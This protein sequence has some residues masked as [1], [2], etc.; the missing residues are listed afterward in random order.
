MNKFLPGIFEL[1]FKIG[2]NTSLKA[3][4]P[5]F[6][7]V[8][9]TGHFYTGDSRDSTYQQIDDT[10]LCL[11][12]NTTFPGEGSHW[13]STTTVSCS[14]YNLTADTEYFTF[15]MGSQFLVDDISR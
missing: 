1:M 12:T 2:V 4:P 14:R 11:L 6:T 3:A 13:V 7:Q 15:N 5:T 8:S 10:D 9:G